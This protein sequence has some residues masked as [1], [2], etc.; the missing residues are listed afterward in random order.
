MATKRTRAVPGRRRLSSKDFHASLDAIFRP[1]SVAVIGA[2]RRR[3]AIGHEI[4]RN[5]VEYG[6]TGP[7]YPVNP[8]ADVVH[9]MKSYATLDEIPD[10][11]DLAVVTV[12]REHVM[13]VIDQC[14]KKGVRG[15]VVITAG[16]KE[17]DEEGRTLESEVARKI[18][19][20]GMRM[21]G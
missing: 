3:H 8:A 17:V 18:D 6:F 12:P 15:L 5:L 11:V 19:K 14:G 7:V 21:V 16:F 2:S 20:Y 13:K 4:L 1:R 10:P 9:S